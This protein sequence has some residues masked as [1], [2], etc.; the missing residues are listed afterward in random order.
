MLTNDPKSQNYYYTQVDDSADSQTDIAYRKGRLAQA[1]VTQSASQSTHQAKYIM[2]KLVEE[3]TTPYARSGTRNL[4]GLLKP[5]ED[6]G[7]ALTRQR[8][9]EWEQTL[10]SI[11]AGMGLQS[12]PSRIDVP[13]T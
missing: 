3:T 13:R 6:E 11:H 8:R 12:D 1:S 4:L 9:S 10:S 2:G 7:R 5:F